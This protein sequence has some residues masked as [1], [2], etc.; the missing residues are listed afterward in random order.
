MELELVS[1]PNQTKSQL[2][3]R[4]RNYKNDLDNLNRQINKAEQ[5]NNETRGGTLFDKETVKKIIIIEVNSNIIY[6]GPQ[7]EIFK[8]RRQNFRAK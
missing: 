2:N 3:Q 6:E 5:K 8:S 7:R 1:L 4:M